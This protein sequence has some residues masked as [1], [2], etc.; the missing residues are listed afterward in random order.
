LQVAEIFRRHGAAFA[1]THALSA[2]QRRVLDAVM[3]CRTAALGGHL[4]VCSHCGHEQPSYNSCRNRHCPTCQALQQARWIEARTERIL[5][6]HHFHVVFTLPA[7]LRPLARCNPRTL[8][9][10]LFAAAAQTLLQLGWDR[11]GAQLGIT[12]V[13]HTWTR[14]ML[15][16]PHLH[17][18]VTGGGL[19]RDGA[20]W[21]RARRNY[22]FPGAVMA[23][24][25]RGKL[26]AALD[27]AYA[28]GEL[29]FH[30]D[31]A[32][33][34]DPAA[35]AA[36]RDA[37]YR[38]RWVVY[39]KR[40]FGDAQKVVAY[41]GRYTHRVAISNAR[42]IEISDAQIV[43]RTRGDGVVRLAPHE[44]IRRFLLHV[45]P[46]GFR[47]IRHYGLLAPSS[48]EKRWPRARALL[49]PDAPTPPSAA[50]AAATSLT[51]EQ[52][53]EALVGPDARIC[54]RCR[55]G[56]LLRT[57]TL[58]PVRAARAASEPLPRDTS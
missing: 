50:A 1:R 39:A 31:C 21:K 10:L 33:L 12:A 34:A 35:F 24:L 6:T 36:L 18:I 45:L 37:L 56:R 57:R 44:F 26:L 4:D 22:L 49:A 17:C 27:A 52:R 42:L 41:L 28:A 40:P 14:Q 8:Y 7:E 29:E 51:W 13:L 2:Q 11:L 19:T 30:G 15:L 25:L 43:L 20:R 32:A 46:S 58:P 54:P 38:K 48:L 16:H 55:V 23:E 9:S 53:L 5:P 3:A 47:K